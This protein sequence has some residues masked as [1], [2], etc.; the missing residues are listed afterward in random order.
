MISVFAS[1]Q[2]ILGSQRWTLQV[3]ERPSGQADVVAPRDLQ[4]ALST[5]DTNKLSGVPMVDLDL[6]GKYPGHR[7]QILQ[8]SD[9]ICWSAGF[10]RRLLC[11][12]AEML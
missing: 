7:S 12:P 9:P 1:N 6:S 10:L 8:L 3:N 4:W 5:F 11:P 2:V